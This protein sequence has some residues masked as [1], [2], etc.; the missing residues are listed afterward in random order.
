MNKNKQFNV[1]SAKFSDG[2]QGMKR[3][4]AGSER[5]F[6]MWRNLFLIA[7]TLFLFISPADARHRARGNKLFKKG[8]DLR[9]GISLSQGTLYD[10]QNDR[11]ADI[12][13]T[14]IGGWAAAG[15]R[16]KTSG[17][18]LDI[19]PGYNKM[20]GEI[21]VGTVKQTW[22]E[23]NFTFPAFLTGRYFFKIHKKLAFV[24]SAGLGLMGYSLQKKTEY[25]RINDVDE[26]NFAL[27]FGMGMDY[28]LNRRLYV[29]GEL[30]YI[31]AFAERT[32]HYVGTQLG[33][34]YRF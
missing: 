22:D 4:L 30:N 32:V 5:S 12:S 23:G 29:T 19:M 26:T 8:F 27:K 2:F 14:H 6:F 24:P 15:Y 34:G 25:G 1:K 7:L 3:P 16:W 11:L 10:V 21:S 28:M 17:I 33:I 9:G 13:I 18:Y 31:P 20:S